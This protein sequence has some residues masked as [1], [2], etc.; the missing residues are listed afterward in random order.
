M[1]FKGN[2]TI[3]IPIIKKK[4]SLQDMYTIPVSYFNV[5]KPTDFLIP[6]KSYK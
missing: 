4:W 3:I 1:N 6:S 2:G 5:F